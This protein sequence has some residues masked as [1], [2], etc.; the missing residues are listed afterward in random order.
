MTVYVVQNPHQA[1][2]ITGRLEPIFDVS[3]A[4]KYG[5]L[6]WLL[7]P[8]ARP[9]SPESVVME[10]HMKLKNYDAK[11]DFILL[12]GN[13]SLIGFTVAIAAQHDPNGCV[14]VL[15]WDGKKREYVE[16]MANLEDP[17]KTS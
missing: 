15:Q 17:C 9:F 10:L 3:P 5:E 13:P 6:S 8:G 7:G 4:E 12:I 2:R 16:I 14:R 11:R 1:N